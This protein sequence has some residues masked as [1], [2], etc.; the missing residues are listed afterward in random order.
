M[1]VYVKYW[2]NFEKIVCWK[3]IELE[4]MI[5]YVNCVDG[6]M[7]FFFYDDFSVVIEVYMIY[8][9]ILWKILLWC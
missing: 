4:V 9:I 7:I 8:F 2:F 3:G 6:K 5:V 1:D